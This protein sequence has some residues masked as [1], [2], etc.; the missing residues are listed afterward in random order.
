ML[1]EFYVILFPLALIVFISYNFYLLLVLE[2]SIIFLQTDKQNCMSN[3]ICL[4]IFC[5]IYLVIVI[6]S[7]NSCLEGVV[8]DN[9]VDMD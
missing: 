7:L 5:F 4:S 2:F 6:W 1:A 8:H 9:P 3:I